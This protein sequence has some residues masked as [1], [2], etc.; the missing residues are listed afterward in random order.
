MLVTI[1]GFGC[2]WWHRFGSDPEDRFRYT[3]H[4][5]FYNSTGIQ[6]GK[7]IRRHWTIPGL[8][9]FN[10]AG[11]FAAQ[12][13]NNLVARTFSCTEPVVAL[14]GNRLLFKEKVPDVTA[15][16]FFLVV[17]SNARFGMLDFQSDWKSK[18]AQPIAASHLRDKQEAMLLMR[19]GSWI[20]TA[21]G[22]WSLM[23]TDQLRVGVALQLLDKSEL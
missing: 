16:D 14:G 9:R 22:R 17:V 2:N 19:L 3:K 5:A 15:P 8:I 21:L 10:G 23:P 4:A 11:N 6:C 13:V 7:K 1:L 20:E 18:D 12:D